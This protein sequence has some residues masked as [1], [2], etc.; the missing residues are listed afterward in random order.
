MRAVLGV[1]GDDDVE[2]QHGAAE[3]D[4]PNSNEDDDCH[5]ST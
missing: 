5:E 1:R 3:K 2:C 4:D